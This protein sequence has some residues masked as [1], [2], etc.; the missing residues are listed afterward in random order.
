MEEDF[1]EAFLGS[2]LSNRWLSFS[3]HSMINRCY[4]SLTLHKANK[5]NA[6]GIP[7]NIVFITHALDQSTSALI[8][9]PPTS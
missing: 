8:N 2:F 3:Q 1:G 7:P 9:P 5:Q 4:F 6:L